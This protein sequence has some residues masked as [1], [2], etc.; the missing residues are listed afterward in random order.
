MVESGVVDKA[1]TGVQFFLMKKPF[2]QTNALT[3]ALP[4]KIR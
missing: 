3:E 4:I 2:G 1:M